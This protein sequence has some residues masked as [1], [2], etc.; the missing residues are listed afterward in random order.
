[1]SDH[2]IPVDAVK[3]PKSLKY[4]QP[5]MTTYIMGNLYS[6]YLHPRKILNK[7]VARCEAFT[8][9]Q[10]KEI[11]FSEEN[12]SLAIILHELIHCYIAGTYIHELNNLPNTD[13]EEVV[14]EVVSNNYVKILN[15]A[16]MVKKAIEIELIKRKENEL[17]KQC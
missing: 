15:K 2:K 7:I 10:E 14:C 13:F 12:P 4:G 9:F 1:M 17:K 6:V 5:I 8:S 3:C 16:N 11:R